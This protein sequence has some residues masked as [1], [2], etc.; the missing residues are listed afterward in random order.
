MRLARGLHPREENNFAV[1]KADALVSFWT[2]LTRVLFTVV[3]AVVFIGIV[4]GGIV[5]MNIML[6]SVSE[7][8]FEIG[9]R[10]ALGATRRDIRR[11]FLVEAVALSTLGGLL[12]VAGGWGLAL[13]VSAATPLPAQV[14]AWS[15]ATAL[16]LGAGTGILFGVYPAVRAARLDPITALRAE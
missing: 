5:I 12:G 14:T 7:R 16:A 1:D 4:V 11:Q 15:V 9:I 10:K 6:M 8:T 2:D 3:P 13:L